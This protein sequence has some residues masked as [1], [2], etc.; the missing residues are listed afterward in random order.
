[1]DRREFLR[2]TGVAGGVIAVA[3]MIGACNSGE[4]AKQLSWLNWQDYI[5][6]RTIPDFEAQSGIDVVYQTYSSNDELERKLIQAGR[7]RRGGRSAR[8]FDLIVPSDNFIARFARLNLLDELDHGALTG[9]DNLAPELRDPNYDPGNRYS[10]PW[11]TGTTGIGYDSTVF[12]EPPSWDVFLNEKYAGRMTILEEIRDVFAAALF[13]LGKDP[14]TRSPADIDAAAKQLIAMKQV[15]RGFDS[16]TYLDLL[17]SGDLVA[18][19]AY[20]SDLLLAK[21]RNPD[22]EFSLP[23]EGALRWVDSLAIPK[24]ATHKSNAERFIRF[25]LRPEISAQVSEGIRADTGNRAALQHVPE[26]LRNNPIVFPPQ[27]ALNRLF[28]TADL[29]D[30]EG[31]YADAWSRVQD[32]A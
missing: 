10:I 7:P 17:A 3:P 28:F 4:S 32:A 22:L 6:P 12:S 26:T 24:D 31:L 21:K 15:I 14:N 30:D 9:L 11:A 13:S 23:Q 19:H 27:E 20:S 25:F 29:G 1:M 2:R 5:D 8:S 18:A 16:S